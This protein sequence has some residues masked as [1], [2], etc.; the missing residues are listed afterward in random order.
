MGKYNS[1]FDLENILSRHTGKLL[2]QNLIKEE[3]IPEYK[4]LGKSFI[5]M[6]K[7][8]ATNNNIPINEIDEQ[9][10]LIAMK[11]NE[12]NPRIYEVS[13]ELTFNITHKIDKYLSKRH[14]LEHPNL[15]FQFSRI[16][17]TMMTDK[18]KI[19]SQFNA[20]KD[21]ETNDIMMVTNNKEVVSFIENFMIMYKDI[22]VERYGQFRHFALIALKF[23]QQDKTDFSSEVIKQLNPNKIDYNILF[24]EIPEDL[25]FSFL[26]FVN[27]HELKSNFRNIDRSFFIN[28]YY[29]FN[30]NKFHEILNKAITGDNFNINKN[31][32]AFY[33]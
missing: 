12:F 5:N 10:Y 24:D 15:L 17:Y 1:N 22:P 8:Y 23:A 18:T 28:A 25:K 32:Q 16:M 9:T 4:K 2:S 29:A 7:D 6:L 14:Y 31:A 19:Y 27:N 26:N 20:I 13:P 21:Y 33:D 30:K 3:Q 11:L